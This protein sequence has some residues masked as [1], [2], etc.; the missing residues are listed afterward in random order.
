MRYERTK[1]E[2]RKQEV[3]C[4]K[5]DRKV[6]EIRKQGNIRE[7]SEEQKKERGGTRNRRKE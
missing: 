2:T 4:G 5:E 7:E 6:Q 3:K 1:E